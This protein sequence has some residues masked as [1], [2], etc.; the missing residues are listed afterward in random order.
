MTVP[1]LKAMKAEGRKIVMLTAYD[2]S[3]AAQLE[4]AGVDVALVGD[5]LGM[6]VQGR[7][8]TLPVTID[9]M[10][11]HTAAVARGLS[12]TLLVADLPFM[13]DRDVPT[14]LDSA[15][16]LVAQGGAAMVK[17]EGAGRVCTVIA[18][19]AERDIPVCGHL[20]LTPQSVNRLG[21]YKVQGKTEAAAEQLFAD[22]QAVEAAGADLLVLECVP[23]S[24][25][26]RI[27]AALSIPVIGIGAGIGCDGQVLVV[28]DMLGLTPGKR[29]KFSK[30]FLA[31]RD[32]ISAAIAAYAD[33]V[34]EKRFPGPEHSFS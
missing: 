18:A 34:R 29:P 10:V 24:L 2:A 11:Y 32:A 6:V 26:A 9:D 22:A 17:I 20:G 13:S 16:R 15:A 21:G 1:G 33:D 8:S 4:S 3:F 31:G 12:A 7:S 14:A 27:T 19:L 23:S 28:Y 5:S 30:D 25:A